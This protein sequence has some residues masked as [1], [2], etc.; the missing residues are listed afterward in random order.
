LKFDQRFWYFK[1]NSCS[2]VCQFRPKFM[3]Q[4]SLDRESRQLLPYPY[5]YYHIHLLP[6]YHYSNKFGPTT[7]PSLRPGCQMT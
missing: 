4:T 2:E 3:I 6:Q 5:I 7:N 1:R